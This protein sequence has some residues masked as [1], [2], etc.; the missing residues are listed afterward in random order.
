MT[1][2]EFQGLATDRKRIL[3]IEDNEMHCL[4]TQDCLESEGYRVMSLFS[5]LYF[6]QALADFQPDLVLLDL[7][8]PGVDGFTSLEQLRTSAWSALPVIVISAYAFQKEKQRALNLGAQVY[9][10]K[11]IRL[12]AL[13]QVVGKFSACN[14]ATHPVMNCFAH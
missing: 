7:K 1:V 4:I 14:L 9:L 12:E 3:V 10:T 8:L 6:W 13:L 5:G 11:P 2:A